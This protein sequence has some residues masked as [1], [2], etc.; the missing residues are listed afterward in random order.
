MSKRA[1][2]IA[3]VVAFLVVAGVA[4]FA[5]VGSRGGGPEIETAK[6]TE[7]ELAV[8][9]TAS[10]RVEAGIRAD[11]YPPVAGT[12]D[13]IFVSDGETVTAGD[14]IATL[15]TVQLELQAA[16]ARAGLS[17]AQAQ[18]D[19]IDN[20]AVGPADLTAA[21][22]NVE[23]ARTAYEAAR[24]GL[25]AVGSQAPSDAQIDAAEAATALAKDAYD[26]AAA[27][28]ASDP[29]SLTL[30]AAADQAL[31]G[32]LSAK[33]SEEQVK[34]VD[35]AAA[36]AQAQAG[37]SQA[38]AAW[39]GAEAQ[40]SK[41]NTADLSAQRAAAAAGVKQAA[42]AV[43]AA[44]K[45]LEDATMMAPVDGIV[46]FNDPGAAAAGM[47]GGV[48]GGKPTEGAMVSP[49]SPPFSVVDMAA[50]RFTAEVDEADIARVDVGMT[51]A[52]SLDSFPG[53]E[54]ETK[55]LRVNPVAQPTATG[56]TVFEVEM[57]LSEV[58]VEVLIGMK[59]DAEIKVS[60]QAGALTIPV[61]ALFS[62]GGKDFVYLVADGKL[63]KSEITVGA[64][65]D[66]E[67]EVL[68]GAEAGDVVALSGSTQYVDGM[69]VRP[70]AD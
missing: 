3:A 59:G 32:Y 52:V 44:E 11:V 22:A 36:K 10:G 26:F 70:K 58:P 38:Y 24:K 60:S 51:A 1:R 31:V 13:E 56:G 8:T 27:A 14:K 35:L 19:A 5:V 6:V 18:Y 67:V 43:S 37:V 28:A 40:L 69:A 39:K 16:Q 63:K 23:A 46:I 25:A 68:T 21:R 15:D 48:A 17:Q 45:A 62:E 41:L 47:S 30:Q 2:I 53:E 34:S 66:T 12:L 65:T 64:T 29:T 54:F 4:A 49:Q 50:L 9:V 61:E 7:Q 42:E 57:A 55:V 20:Q 33:A